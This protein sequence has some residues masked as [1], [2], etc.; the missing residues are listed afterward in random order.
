MRLES[1][2]S[3]VGGREEVPVHRARLVARGGAGRGS[4][5]HARGVA[6]GL[7]RSTR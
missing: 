1:L 5:V 3:V 4:R 2:S 7:V 6:V